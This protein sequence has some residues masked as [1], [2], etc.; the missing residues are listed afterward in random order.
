[1]RNPWGTDGNYNGTWN[2]KDPLWL[3][4]VNNFKAQV[5]YINNTKDGVFYI[6]V[7]DFY[8]TF[9]GFS[10]SFQADTYKNSISTVYNDTG[11][12]T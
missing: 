9:S 3:D 5:P 8:R 12:L 10:V 6:S 7:D 1:M 2:D 4:T 11:N